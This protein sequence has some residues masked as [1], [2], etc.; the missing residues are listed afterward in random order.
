MVIEQEFTFPSDD[1]IHTVATTWW[2]PE[3][4]PWGV[5]QLIH[6]I[7][8]HIGRHDSFARFLAEHDFAIVDHDHLGHNHTAWNPLKFG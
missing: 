1:G 2:R 8:K 3:G 4:P 6:S 5:M 7:S